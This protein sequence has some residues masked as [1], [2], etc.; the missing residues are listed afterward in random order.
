MPGYLYVR[1]HKPHFAESAQSGVPSWQQFLAAAAVAVCLAAAYLLRSA[2]NKPKVLPPPR[3]RKPEPAF[4]ETNSLARLFVEVLALKEGTPTW[5]S[6]LKRLNPSDN[7]HTRT[8]LLELRSLPAADPEA[9]LN[10]IEQ[11]CIES[12]REGQDPSQVELL[13]RALAGLR[14]RAPR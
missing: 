11:I 2:K 7:P 6:I 14:E 4:H 8:I 3:S 9:V 12:K 5:P 1:P 13:E 10:A